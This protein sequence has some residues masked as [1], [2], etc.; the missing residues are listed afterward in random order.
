MCPVYFYI[1]LGSERPSFWLGVFLE[2]V[3]EASV[4]GEASRPGQREEAKAA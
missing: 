1:P 2:S 4:S 3:T